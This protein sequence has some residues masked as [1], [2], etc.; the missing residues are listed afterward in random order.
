MDGGPRADLACF[1]KDF[2]RKVASEY[3]DQ[4]EEMLAYAFQEFQLGARQVAVPMLDIAQCRN[5]HIVTTAKS[6]I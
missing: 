1:P 4:I 6:S 2:G 3:A 5:D